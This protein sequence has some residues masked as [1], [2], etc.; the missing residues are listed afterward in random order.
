MPAQTT[1]RGPLLTLMN[2]RTTVTEREQLQQLAA[3]KGV[4]VTHL[5]RQGLRLQGFEPER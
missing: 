3:R 4:T 1:D 2:F 5:I